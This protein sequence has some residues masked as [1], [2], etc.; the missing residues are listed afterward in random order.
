MQFKTIVVP[1]LFVLISVIQPDE[2]KLIQAKNFCNLISKDC[3]EKQCQS[4]L[5]C[6]SSVHSY[7]CGKSKCSVNEKECKE[8]LRTEGVLRS[9][10]DSNYNRKLKQTFFRF[11]N[12]FKMCPPKT[13]Y[14]WTENDVCSLKKSCYIDVKDTLFDLLFLKKPSKIRT[15]C[16]CKSF[17][18]RHTFECIQ[19]YCAR[20]RKSCVE[21]ARMAPSK[22]RN[23]TIKQCKYL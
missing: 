22:K 5:K 4:E 23:T 15:Y 20:D 21:F 18:Q 7:R 3:K 9:M 11:Q 1:F 13:A 10:R 8:F 19:G 14:N 16:P 12:E 2:T 6:H 17:I